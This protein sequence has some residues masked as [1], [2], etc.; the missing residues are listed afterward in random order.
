M[1]AAIA[2]G[3]PVKGAL[4]LLT[5]RLSPGVQT[6]KKQAH[7]GSPSQ[8]PAALAPAQCYLLVHSPAVHRGKR[9]S[10][11]SQS[12]RR[13]GSHAAAA[14]TVLY[15]RRRG[16]VARTISHDN[17]DYRCRT[18]AADPY[19][20]VAFVTAAVMRRGPRDITAGVAA[21]TAGW[22]LQDISSGAMTRFRATENGGKRTTEIPFILMAPVVSR[23]GDTVSSVACLLHGSMVAAIRAYRRP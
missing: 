12:Y 23:K 21:A 2:G 11:P 6:P 18:A 7:H 9:P 19:G 10:A 16:S 5:M 13:G 4:L 15:R 17:Y 20:T 8:H 22:K 1:V 3:V 14:A